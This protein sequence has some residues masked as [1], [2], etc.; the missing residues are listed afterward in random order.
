MQLKPFPLAPR[1]FPDESVRSWLARVAA[2]YDLRIADLVECLRGRG[3]KR[4][5]V[6]RLASIDWLEDTD[7][8]HLLARAARLDRA[9]I[10]ALRVP[11]PARSSAQQGD[12]YR[13]SVA[14]CPDCVR[15]DFERHG[16]V[17]ERAV[18]RLGCCVACPTHRSPLEHMC[19]VCFFGHCRFSPINGRQRLMC[20]GCR[21]P[22]DRV[23]AG[24]T[25][26]YSASLRRGRLELIPGSD[27]NRSAM[28]LQADIL[29]ALIGL[30]PTGAWQFGL[31]PGQFALVVRDLVGLFEWPAGIPLS[32]NEDKLIVSA[33]FGRFS[34]IEPRD[35]VQILGCIG[36]VLTDIAGGCPVRLRWIDFTDVNSDGTKVD[37]PWFVRHLPKDARQWLRATAEGWGPILAPRI[38]AAVDT[39]EKRERDRAAAQEQAR[40]NATLTKAYSARPKAVAKRLQAAASRRIAARARRRAAFRR[41][42]KDPEKGAPTRVSRRTASSVV[43]RR[44]QL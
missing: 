12:W 13:W 36:S 6:S 34:E 44:I 39:Q 10:S 30:A 19:Q 8:E 15:G 11:V 37:L 27:L 3:E 17:Y 21:S 5:D 7:L 18:W 42:Q 41:K 31:T 20:E 25:G 33:R 23:E 1:P 28:D 35:G 22:V 4:I 26:E 9:S 2:R 38:G 14:W 40:R 29:N 32:E 16:E 24:G 43:T